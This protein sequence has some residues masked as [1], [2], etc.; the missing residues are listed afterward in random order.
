MVRE[1][2]IIEIL[3][4]SP[5]IALLRARSSQTILEFF[6]SVFDETTVI[7]QENLYN[8]LAEFLDKFSHWDRYL[9]MMTAMTQV[10]TTVRPVPPIYIVNTFSYHQS[11]RYRHL[12]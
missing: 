10:P 8:Q 3:N 5:S 1:S 9:G 2:N 11:G 7:S 12:H 6:T 4:S